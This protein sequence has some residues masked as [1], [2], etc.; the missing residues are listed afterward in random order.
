VIDY[1]DASAL[2]AVLLDEPARH[3]V[4]AH[5][6]AA[7]APPQVSDFVVA[8]VSSA[9]SRLLRMELRDTAQAE[10]LIQ[11]LDEWVRETGEPISLDASDA[12]EATLLVRRFDL[13]L[14]APDALHLAICRRLQAR[15]VTLDNNL[16]RAARALDVPCINPAETSAL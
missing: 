9:I 14:R 5:I 1:F 15:L 13:K 16:A 11:S 12:R 10:A 4:N 3:R 6:A 7:D 2:A 8:E